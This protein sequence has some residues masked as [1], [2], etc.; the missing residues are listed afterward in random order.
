[1]DVHYLWRSSFYFLHLFKISRALFDY[2]TAKRLKS[3]YEK[4]SA[5]LASVAAPLQA[6]FNLS[7]ESSSTV[8]KPSVQVYEGFQLLVDTRAL[9]VLENLLYCPDRKIRSKVLRFLAQMAVFL[10]RLDSSSRQQ[11]TIS[12][13][14]QIISSG[15][16]IHGLIDVLRGK[17]AEV[18]DVAATSCIIGCL[19]AVDI[20]YILVHDIYMALHYVTTTPGQSAEK[21]RKSAKEALSSLAANQ[22]KAIDALMNLGEVDNAPRLAAARI[23]TPE[24]LLD[25]ARDLNFGSTIEEQSHFAGNLSSPRASSSDSCLEKDG[26]ALRNELTE[27]TVAGEAVKL[28]T[29]KKVN[30][31]TER[32]KRA[33]LKR[34][35]GT[36]N[37]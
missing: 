9:R 6:A 22:P 26:A 20:D 16:F 29:L 25:E 33:P 17:R 2:M 19:A 18:D 27:K 12:N 30:W 37:A 1:M 4:E 31:T 15:G 13:I 3:N 23:V 34:D 28:T 5:L 7:K 36:E 35:T 24:S 32:L 21:A 11:C 14:C 10:S 8:L